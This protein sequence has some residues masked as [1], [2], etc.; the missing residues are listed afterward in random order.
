MTEL[1]GEHDEL[2]DRIGPVEIPSRVSLRQS[3]S[4]SILQGYVELSSTRELIEQVVD[5]A[6]QHATHPPHLRGRLREPLENRDA[7]ANGR[8]AQQLPLGPARRVPQ[9]VT[10]GGDDGLVGGDDVS[11]ARQGSLDPN[12]C[13]GRSSDRFDDDVHAPQRFGGIRR[14]DGWIDARGTR[15][16]GVAHEDLPHVEGVGQA[17]QQ[18]V[19]AAADGPG[20]QDGDV[21]RSTRHR[22]RHAQRGLS[23]DQ[24]RLLAVRAPQLE[25]EPMGLSKA[26]GLVLQDRAVGRQR[27]F[28]RDGSIARR[29]RSRTSRV[30]LVETVDVL[31]QAADRSVQPTGQEQRR[32]VGSPATEHDRSAGRVPSGEAGHH[33]NVVGLQGLR[34]ELRAHSTRLG[35]QGWAVRDQADHGR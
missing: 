12:A 9:R 32:Q 15:A 20:T 14:H 8:G 30:P 35:I 16:L 34:D 13:V 6:I 5:R 17:G 27:A 4:P 33:D 10:V 21:E 2:V 31:D 3:Q 28:P 1:I 18:L 7:S 25:R 19:Q 23:T 26:D 24:R 22:A 29:R 11:S